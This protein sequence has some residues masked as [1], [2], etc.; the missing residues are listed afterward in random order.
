MHSGI[1]I[2]F[3]EVDNSRVI[4][5][6]SLQ[7]LSRKCYLFFAYIFWQGTSFYLLLVHGFLSYPV[8]QVI[9]ALTSEIDKIKVEILSNVYIL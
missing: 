8:D 7:Q 4:S 9:H 2:N 3:R 6:I 5:L 1:I